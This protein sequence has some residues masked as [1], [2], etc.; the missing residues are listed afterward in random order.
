MHKRKIGSLGEVSAIGFGCLSFGNFYG[1]ADHAE[2]LEAL[3]RARDVG[4]DH[5][6]TSNVYGAG[7]SE[8]IVGEFL[9]AN[10]GAFRIATKCGITRQK[11]KPYDNAPDYMRECLEG[12]LR[13]LGVD[14]IDLYYVH[15]REQD[16]PIED[17]VETLARFKKEGKIGSIGFSEISP[18]S[19]ERAH[20]VHPVDAVQSEYSLWTRQPELGMIQACERL[21]TTLVAFSPLGRGILVDRPPQPANFDDKDFRKNNPRFVEP[22]FSSNM[23]PITRFAQ[24]ARDHSHTPEALAIAWVLNRAPHIVPIPG[25]RYGDH[26]AADAKAAEIRLSA[27]QMAE[28]EQILPAGF[29]H[30]NR[31]TA[32]QASGVEQYC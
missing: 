30:G 2:S 10:P 9:K 20:A 7:R 3:G 26:I 1:P 18:A 32:A 22:N 11:E 25:T 29:A 28:I 24:Y 23:K 17:V 6:D 21:G 8:E 14:H 15:R 5:I 16:R 13:R 19:L 27:D 4:I 31:Y 12:S